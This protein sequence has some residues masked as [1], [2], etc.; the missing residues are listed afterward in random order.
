[1]R[2][3][4]YLVS[5]RVIA[6]PTNLPDVHAGRPRAGRRFEPIAER[7][8]SESALRAAR[9]LPGA[10]R[11]VRILLE[12][13]GPFGVP[14]LLAIVG[15]LE[16]LD[17]RLALEVPPLLNQVD[18]GVISATAPAAARTL[19]TLAKRL[20]W[21]VETVQRRLPHLLRIGALVRA[22]AETY[23]RPADLA[24]VGRL[25]AI[26]AKVRDWRRALRQARTY[27]VW[28]DGYV[29]VM[30]EVGASSLPGLL[31]EVSRDRGGLMLNG[32]WVLRPRLL[33]RTPAQRLWGSEHAIAAFDPG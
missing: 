18:A 4:A 20:S 30:P 16:L 14:D 28:T 2:A 25:F 24:S 10:H 29:I 5:A 8:L 13:A 6:M 26:E 11:G 19:E 3:A 17:R 12:T 27:S 23:V 15:P 1:M 9:T 31:A 22:G 21:P 7:M 32:K 33:T